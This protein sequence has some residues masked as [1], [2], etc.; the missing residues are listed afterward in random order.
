MTVTDAVAGPPPAASAALPARSPA[1]RSVA[2]LLIVGGVLLVTFVRY[3]QMAEA[4]ANGALLNLLHIAPAEVY[5]AAVVFLPGQTYI[6]YRV[7]A[8]CT[9]TLLLVPFFF[10]T[11]GLLSF[12]RL[13]PRRCL[14]ALGLV[15]VLIFTANQA[16]MLLIASVMRVL[17]GERGYDA[18]HVFL[19]TVVST[20]GV[21]GAIVVFVAVLVGWRPSRPARN[22]ELSPVG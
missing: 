14:V 2:A 17:G 22:E 19:G 3:G 16:R 21:L 18:S 6:G 4:Q 8:G 9:A 11:A 20:L 7:D 13:S 5:G 15:S 10:L 12:S 1:T